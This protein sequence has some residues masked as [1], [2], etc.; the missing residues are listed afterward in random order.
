MIG[1]EERLHAPLPL[2]DSQAPHDREFVEQ[3]GE[4]VWVFCGTCSAVNIARDPV[5]RNIKKAG[6]LPLLSN[7][8]STPDPTLSSMNPGQEIA[9]DSAEV[10]RLVTTLW[11]RQVVIA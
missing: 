6:S 11:D 2:F 8:V 5:K 7:G 3:R 10:P 4:P 1:A 9:F